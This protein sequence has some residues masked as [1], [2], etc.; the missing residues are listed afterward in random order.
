MRDSPLSYPLCIKRKGLEAVL[1]RAPQ[2]ISTSCSQ[3]FYNIG[4]RLLVVEQDKHFHLVIFSAH[5]NAF[6]LPLCSKMRYF[7]GTRQPSPSITPEDAVVSIDS[8]VQK[9]G[10]N[11]ELLF[12]SDLV[13]I[14]DRVG[15]SVSSGS[16]SCNF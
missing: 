2:A 5:Q 8:C 9:L 3:H 15:L 6:C 12:Q 1:V 10:L 7:S 4:P 11:V 16:M 13:T 14:I